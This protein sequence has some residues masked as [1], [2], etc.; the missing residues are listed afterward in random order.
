MDELAKYGPD[1]I[2]NISASPFSYSRLDARRNIFINKARKH[3][4][5][6]IAV[7]QT[8]ANTELIFD[9]AS[10][11][12]NGRGE[13]ADQLPS[14]RQCLKT[15]PW[16]EIMHGYEKSSE[17]RDSVSLI[18]EA[19]VTGISDY[20]SKLG[21]SK[22][23]LGLSGGIDS[24]VCLS[25]AA[26]ALGSENVTALL[27]PS[28]YSSSHSV[29]DAVRL[30]DNLG[31][32]YE[33]I[34]IEKPFS[35]F[36]DV[37]SP[38]FK[39]LPQDVT[40][41]NIQARIRAVIL[42]AWSNK[43]GHILLNTSNKSEAAVGYGTLYGDMAGGL[44]VIGD[45]YKTDVYRLAALINAGGEIIPANTVLKPPSAELKPGQFDSDSLPEYGLLDAILYRYIEQQKSAADIIAEGYDSG[46]VERI[47]A[48]INSNEY[49][50]YQA[51]PILRISSKAFGAG[52][53]MPLVARYQY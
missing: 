41:E 24:A 11:V 18:R 46:E 35:A 8:G 34:N 4:I 9:G 5:P 31:V 19:L 14:F 44:S 22:A 53:R 28:R 52:R 1:L 23:V 33:I 20:F 51:P 42:M 36:G 30:A 10:L 49:K 38:V 25:L 48:M 7:N 47:I 3:A 32:R 40:E 12:V 27:L 37:L 39:G 16:D 13:I 29:D 26:E 6:V 15:Y 50:R 45:V 17:K 43:F 2:I 21:F